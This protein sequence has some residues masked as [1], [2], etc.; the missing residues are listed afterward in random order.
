MRQF[1]LAVVVAISGAATALAAPVELEP[2]T[3]ARLDEGQRQRVIVEFAVPAVEYARARGASDAEVAALIGDVRDRVLT[4]A[5]GRPAGMMAT[6]DADDPQGPVVARSFRYTPAAAMILSA[7]EIAVLAREPGVARIVSDR[8]DRVSLDESVG[9]IGGDV[10]HTRGHSGAGTAIAILDTGVDLQHDMFASRTVGSACFSSTVQGQSTSLCPGGVAEAFGGQAGDNCETPPPG[11]GSGIAECFHGTHVA[12]IA[13]G[14]AI[15]G[16]GGEQLVGVAP[17]AQLVAVQVFSRFFGTNYCGA[18]IAC[19]YSYASDQIAALE[20]VYDQRATLPLVAVNMSLGG[21]QYSEA[22]TSDPRRPIITALREANIATVIAT[23]NDGFRTSLSA[24]ACIPEGVA[25]T[26][27]DAYANKGFWEDLYAPGTN[28][29]SASPGPNDE[30]G[31]LTVNATGTS[32]AAPHVAGAFALLR[33]A[34][35]ESGIDQAETALITT[36][37]SYI[38]IDSAAE[39]LA[40]NPGNRIGALQLDTTAQIRFVHRY[41]DDRQDLFHEVVVSNPSSSAAGWSAES[42]QNWVHLVRSDTQESGQRLEGSLEP[43][44]RVTI[45]VMPDPLALV[46]YSRSAVVEFGSPS[47]TSAISIPVELQLQSAMPANDDFASALELNAAGHST[48]LFM[49]GLATAQAGEPFHAGLPP[50][51]TQW[52]SFTPDRTRTYNI[53]VSP[54]DFDSVM[55]IYTGSSLDGLSLVA[56]N[57]DA[58]SNDR[59]S[60]VDLAANAGV[61]YHIAS[62]SADPDET[63]TGVVFVRTA[64]ETPPNDLIA[65][66]IPISGPRGLVVADMEGATQTPEELGRPGTT[67][68]YVWTAPR[69][70]TYGFFAHEGRQSQYAD[71]YVDVA[72]L[73]EHRRGETS[74]DIPHS[75]TRITVSAGER[76][77]VGL[78]MRGMRQSPG[79]LAWYPIEEHGQPLRAAVIPGARSVRLGQWATTFVTLVNPASHGRTMTNCRIRA[80]GKFSGGF[81]FQ[82]TD[83]VT[84]A[85]TGSRDTPVSIP[86]GQSQSFLVA[87]QSAHREAMDFDLVFTCDDVTAA[88]ATP[89][90]TFRLSTDTI[91]AL[92]LIHI[93]ATSSGNGIL[94]LVPGATRAFAIAV[95]NAGETGRGSIRIHSSAGGDVAVQLC[96]T[97]PTTGRCVSDRAQS[98]NIAMASGQ[99]RTFTVFVTLQPGADLPFDPAN[100]RVG[101]D[102]GN[103]IASVAVRSSQ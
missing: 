63:G 30:G 91:P 7:D 75:G 1:A 24:P 19:A 82:T 2:A 101:I 48:A 44:Q 81:H 96:E 14:G 88:V 25:V 5:F 8:L 55:A 12:G 4:A 37:A 49:N 102:F 28:I 76:F 69:D 27:L 6:L 56:Q 26:T 57:N 90:T 89:V 13:L 3:E 100:R 73:P 80:P 40:A 38:R 31:S 83:P 65:G 59:G 61:T 23:G 87:I 29:L 20:W 33:Q 66:A 77:Y 32:M 62:G 58:W 93:A 84:N 18:E 79:Q 92:D 97:D 99:V 71:L 103:S 10:M 85:L 34:V 47:A 60:M 41:F 16:S 35:P 78:R 11:G 95:A 64:T 51:A 98:L 21:G 9:G 46:F 72:Q 52:W 53:R 54:G 17:G 45:Q 15:S 68:W 42:D 67:I 43:G 86:S 74:P 50:A 22:C 36:T 39:T 70:G 94:D